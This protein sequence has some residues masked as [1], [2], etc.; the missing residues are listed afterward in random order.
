MNN[1]NGKNQR[2]FLSIPDARFQKEF[3]VLMLFVALSSSAI[4]ML[5]TWFMVQK[6]TSIAMTANGGLGGELEESIARQTP[7]IWLMMV[8]VTVVNAICIAIFAFAF[9]KRASGIV[10]RVTND[11]NRFASGEQVASINPR[12][13]DFFLELVDAANRVMGRKP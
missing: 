7:N 12:E 6:I 8:G 9:S 10:R 3:T 5:G 1:P 11:L 13:G 2:R 4:M